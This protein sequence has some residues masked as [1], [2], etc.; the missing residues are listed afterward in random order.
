MRDSAVTAAFYSQQLGFQIIGIY[1]DYLIVKRDPIEIHFF[2]HPNMDP[3]T[4]DGQVYIRVNGIDALY[5]TWLSQGVSI[6]PNGI[7]A[8]K[9]WGQREFAILDP[10]FNLL[11]F[12]EPLMRN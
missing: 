4:N 2:L 11:T 9:P 1:P 3:H 5:Q 8:N 6:H 7:L 10:D 12:G